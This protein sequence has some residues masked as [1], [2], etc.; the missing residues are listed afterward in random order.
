MTKQNLSETIA[1]GTIELAW[2]GF[3]GEATLKAR[4]LNV[5]FD[6]SLG[7]RFGARRVTLL[8]KTDG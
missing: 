7:C 5:R 2:I 4:F 3:G 6:V 1:A 8:Q